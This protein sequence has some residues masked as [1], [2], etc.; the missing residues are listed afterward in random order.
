[1]GEVEMED[2]EEEE[3]E[4]S[5]EEIVE[6]DD[7]EKVASTPVKEG[8]DEVFCICRSSDIERF[9]I[10]CEKCNEWFHGDC[11]NVSRKKAKSIEEWFC[12]K[13]LEKDKKLKKP[14][15]QSSK[16]KKLLK[17]H[18]LEDTGESWQD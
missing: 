4:E 3:I 11:I 15:K 13:C 8:G 14:A 6:E 2:E 1:M 12:F 9:M 18:V 5:E 7:D 16:R 17:T 10:A